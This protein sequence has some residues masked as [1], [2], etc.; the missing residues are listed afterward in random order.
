MWEARERTAVTPYASIETVPATEPG[1]REGLGLLLEAKLLWGRDTLGVRHL[2]VRAEICV[3][4][5]GFDVPACDDLVIGELDAS[6]AF[7]LRLPNGTAVPD[8]CRMTLRIGRALL[9]LSLVPDDVVKL[10]RA[11]PD[12][13][14]AFGILGAAVLHLVVLGLVAH[15]RGAE[16]PREDEARETMQRMV[17][18][19]EER[20]LAEL[21]AAQEK[22]RAE[23][24][25]GVSAP[26]PA[27]EQAAADDPPRTAVKV[28]RARVTP[29]RDPPSTFGLLAVLGA[30]SAATRVGASAFV[31]E[32]GPS[33]MG[34][35]FGQTIDDA[36]GLGGLGL[37]GQ[38]EGGGGFA[39]GVKAAGRE[40]VVS[41]PT[42][43]WAGETETQVDGP[44]SP[45]AVQRTVRQTFGRLGACYEEGL[46]RNPDLEGRVAVKLVVG[47]DG[48][49]ALA[50]PSAG[51]TLPDASVAQCVTRVFS[52]MVFSRSAG[53]IVTVVYPI[54]LTRTSP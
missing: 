34:S 11:T 38:A 15:S 45:E 8:G 53:G 48:E 40:H 30:D 41:S 37:T 10:P 5:L 1:P 44:L 18:S 39:A 25:P 31:A 49:V 27:K 35:I 4:D 23:T 26:T 13:R 43:L 51:T 29:Q 32:S 7:G 14:T 16:G 17:A 22:S 2:P 36:A 52:A 3:R 24:T 47:S 12:S 50:S 6:G 9:R 42:I 46:Q 33:A 28:A 54:V 19:A 20:A 21:A